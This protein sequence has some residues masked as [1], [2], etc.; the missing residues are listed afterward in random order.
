MIT[1]KPILIILALVYFGI[2]SLPALFAVI[3][4]L[5]FGGNFRIFA[6]IPFVILLPN[7]I[8]LI[9]LLLKPKKWYQT[10]CS[11]IGSIFGFGSFIIHACNW[12]KYDAFYKNNIGLIISIIILCIFI[13][14]EFNNKIKRY[15]ASK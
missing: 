15:F 7:V 13:S 8:G 4:L 9:L 10:Y 12:I 6:I 5:A 14:L 1:K 11:A 2:L 3:Y